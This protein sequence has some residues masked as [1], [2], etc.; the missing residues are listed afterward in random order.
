MYD[1]GRGS[2]GSTLG[3]MLAD[4]NRCV[5]MV[6]GKAVKEANIHTGYIVFKKDF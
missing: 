6:Q 2:E 3:Y 5:W 4:R 1:T